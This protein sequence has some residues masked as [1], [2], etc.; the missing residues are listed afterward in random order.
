M[1]ELTELAKQCGAEVR[2]YED[3]VYAVRFGDISL[4]A[5]V[6]RIRAEER[7]RIANQWDGCM[8]DAVG[9]TIDVGASIRASDAKHDGVALPATG[10]PPELLQDCDRKLSM[11]LSNTPGARLHAKEAA[12]AIAKETDTDAKQ[13]ARS[14][15]WTASD[16]MR[17]WATPSHA[18]EVLKLFYDEWPGG[19]GE[20]E[21]EK[22]AA[23]VR[24]ASR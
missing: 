3:D 4:P 9:E 1:C 2:I 18:L 8:Y 11:A 17:H 23:A 6:E 15:E 7:E 12:D 21:A 19:V 16:G 10:R 13:E 5:F 22:R 14:L 24:E 20:F